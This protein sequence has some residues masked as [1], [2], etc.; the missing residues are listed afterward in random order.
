MRHP[1][2]K[3]SDLKDQLNTPFPRPMLLC[4]HCGET[5][6][7]HSGDYFVAHP[8]HIF[9]HCGRNMRLVIKR[10]TFEDVSPR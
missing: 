8:S 2:I 6:S 4:S 3:V 5:F 9:K 7:A 1:A 10:V